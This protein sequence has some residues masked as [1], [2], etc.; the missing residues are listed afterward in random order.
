MVTTIN[1]EI[2]TQPLIWYNIEYE[3]TVF[4][5]KSSSTFLVILKLKYY[6]IIVQTN[7][8]QQID[9]QCKS[10][11][12]RYDERTTYTDLS[13]SSVNRHPER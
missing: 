2:N 5:L 3:N 7:W 11:K 8:A 10:T 1:I 12:S 6:L 9:A 4:Q 13:R